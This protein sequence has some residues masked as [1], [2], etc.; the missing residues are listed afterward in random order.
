[1]PV[2]QYGFTDARRRL[3]E[4]VDG[5]QS[6][7]PQLIRRRKP[8]EDGVVLISRRLLRK[9]LAARK[10]AALTVKKGRETDGS[11]TL[12]FPRFGMAVNSQDL[13]S[14]EIEL[15]NDIKSYAEDYI[16]NLELYGRSTNRADHLPAI[17]QII[18]C[19]GI[20]ELRE[21]VGLA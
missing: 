16:E 12:T 20:G 11:Y 2:S 6:G 4:L 3:T 7:R 13:K 18:S 5:A 9:A 19:D 21:L 1:M 17:V 8:S 10:G 15:L 14:A